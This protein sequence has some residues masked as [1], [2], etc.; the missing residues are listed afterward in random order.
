MRDPFNLEGPAVVSFSGGRT[1]AYLLARTLDA[2]HGPDVHVLFA[3][4]G[5]ER[6]ETYAF[7]RECSQRWGVTVH[8]VARPAPAGVSPFE[9]LITERGYCPSPVTRYCTTELKVRPMKAWMLAQGYEHWVNA[10]GLRA[11][12]PSRVV[13]MRD[14]GERERW[15][16]VLPLADAGVTLREVDEFWARQPFDLELQPWEGNCSICFL[17]SISKRERIMRDRPDLAAWWIEQERRTGTLFRADTPSY[18]ALLRRSQQP[19]LPFTEDL[20]GLE[21]V[22]AG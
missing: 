2:G 18:A 8:Q 15:D 5:L 1:S 16:V 20:S 13:R 6:P 21:C 10:V 12:E 19:L 7:V 3:D 17:K 22:C 14:A 11:D 4:T 9:A